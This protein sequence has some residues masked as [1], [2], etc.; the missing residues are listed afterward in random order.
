MKQLKQKDLKPLREELYKKQNGICP[1]C[2]HKITLEEAVVDHQHMTLAETVG[3][4][5]AGLIRGVLCLRCNAVEGGMINKYKRYGV[6][7]KNYPEFLRNLADYLEQEPLPYIH[8]TEAPKIPKLGK[9]DFNKLKKLY[10]EK[11]PRRKELEYP[12]SGKLTKR[13]VEL[14]EEFNIKG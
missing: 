12:K 4:K 5:G 11:Y 3:E 14:F 13:W 9:R 10:K 1:L 8:P 6:Y 2:K 7:L